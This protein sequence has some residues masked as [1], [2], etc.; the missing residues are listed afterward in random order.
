MNEIVLNNSTSYVDLLGI[1][2]GLER[3]P[4]ESTHSF[5]DRVAQSA[6]LERDASYVGQMNEL[7]LQLGFTLQEA[8]VIEAPGEISVDLN[9]IH[10][11]GLSIPLVEIDVD[12]FWRWR[13][14]SEV[15]A[16]LN[17]A[18]A[19]ATLLIEDGPAFQ[20][21]R[22]SNT[23]QR[24][25][26]P[27]DG[28]TLVLDGP[29]VSDSLSFNRSV[30]SYTVQGTLVRFTSPVPAGTEATYKFRPESFKLVSSPVFLMSMVDSALGTLAVDTNGP[31]VYQM[32]EFVQEMME[33]DRSYWAK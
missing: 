20:L 26:Q 17:A 31:L 6:V 10:T 7:M 29:L 2:S 19:V 24:L 25:R 11:L 13:T 22:Q 30:P 1:Q 4:G 27:V 33:R 9:G 15:V 3:I 16:D 8:V 5:A 12:N 32:R 18:G 28:Q 14:L 23:L 21:C